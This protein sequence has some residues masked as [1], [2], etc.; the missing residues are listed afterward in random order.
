MEIK[1][2]IKHLKINKSSNDIINSII[3]KYKIKNIEEMEEQYNDNI[4]II[5]SQSCSEDNNCDSSSLS[6]STINSNS[7]QEERNIF[8]K[9]DIEPKIKNINLNLN[10]DKII[11]CHENMQYNSERNSKNNISTLYNSAKEL[12]SIDSLPYLMINPISDK[13][14]S[15]IIIRNKK[16]NME[17][18]NSNKNEIIDKEYSMTIY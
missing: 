8:I 1:K 5:D 16:K 2:V 17:I 7:I 18:F 4:I 9:T 11:Q 14:N 10:L 3:A 6:S 12:S 15:K 13:A